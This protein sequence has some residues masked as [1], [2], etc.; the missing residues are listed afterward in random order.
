M[1][2]PP[3]ASITATSTATRPGACPV[4]HG[5]QP[6]QRAGE[7]AGQANNVGEVRQQP[8]SGVADHPAT[9]SRDD[10]LE[11]RQ[12]SAATEPHVPVAACPC[13]G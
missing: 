2:S 1:A 4:P 13:R 11:T 8:G 7:G 6:S 5:P 10:K 12:G 9:V 3:S